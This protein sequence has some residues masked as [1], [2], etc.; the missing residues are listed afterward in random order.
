MISR[1]VQTL[2]FLLPFLASSVEIWEVDN[3]LTAQISELN[4]HEK[5][6]NFNFTHSPPT[7]TYPYTLLNSTTPSSKRSKTTTITGHISTTPTV[8]SS[9]LPFTCTFTSSTHIKFT[10]ST[11]SISNISLHLKYPS[12]NETL[13]T[14]LG[15]QFTPSPTSTI[16]S[17]TP[18]P[19]TV[20]EQG[21]G[22]GIQ[23]LTKIMN[24]NYHGAGGNAYSTY[25]PSNV[26]TSNLNTSGY[27]VNTEY[28]YFK[29]E[30]F[31][32]RSNVISGGFILEN[33]YY[34][35]LNELTKVTG[36]F[37]GVPEW[38]GEG[39]VIGLQGGE[40]KVIRKVSKLKDGGVKIAG[41][42]IQD[43]AGKRVDSFGSRVLW[44]WELDGEFYPGW[45]ER[46]KEWEEEGIRTLVYINPCLSTRVEE[47]KPYGRR[48]LFE[49]AKERGF[50]IMRE[51]GEVYVQSSASDEFQFG[52]VDLTDPEAREWYIEV[53][54][55]CNI[56]CS[57][58][59]ANTKYPPLKEF[60]GDVK[61]GMGGEGEGVKGWMADFGE[62]LPFDVVLKDGTD[63]GR[64]HN[65]WP[66]LWAGVNGE[67]VGRKKN[68]KEY[69]F[70][71][72]SG[73]LKSPLVAS[74]GGMFWVGDQ[75]TAWDGNDG[76]ASVLT[77]YLTAGSSGFSLTH[78]DVG[79]YTSLNVTGVVD[80]EETNVY[81]GRT[82][83]LI[84][85]WMELSAVAD[86]MMR[87]H[88][89]NQ[90]DKQLQVWD[91]PDLI[92]SLKFWTDF[93][94]LLH[95]FR[96]VLLKEASKYGWPLVRGMWYDYGMESFGMN[97]QF[98]LGKDLL[99]APVFTPGAETVEIWIPRGEW[100]NLWTC[101]V[102]SVEVPDHVVEVEAPVGRPAIYV[103][104]GEK[105]ARKYSK[106]IWD[107]LGMMEKGGRCEELYKWKMPWSKKDEGEREL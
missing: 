34:E 54:I 44:N 6:G 33:S 77:A 90:A 12:T 15:I 36:R 83:E 100:V 32:V 10:C 21:V 101:E 22:R 65:D 72:R 27:V 4:V 7:L 17:D 97:S 39:V 28:T 91:T 94:V 61:C 23:P 29:D 58:T 18:V 35:C 40:N 19:L 86:C 11:P 53:V 69:L 24:E 25:A 66:S 45:N 93:H 62:Y 38:T 104:W 76:L 57:C 87:T 49:E 63:G 41:L 14:G 13:Y 20:G 46:V 103:T 1:L 26:F 88:E 9:S 81:V 75:N 67:A 42:W 16:F 107:G 51:N 43:W 70:F 80:G 92:A 8:S 78:S 82:G 37:N 50:L 64:R 68:W 95:P 89:G 85:R 84:K 56:M 2:L 79:G 59:V 52:T 71:S 55:N 3:F 30:G 74:K 47:F 99:M 98:M 105:R 73:S 48:N 96:R 60:S 31:E 102:T 106:K 5:D